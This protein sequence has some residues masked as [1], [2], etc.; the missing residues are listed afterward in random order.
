MQF[1]DSRKRWSFVLIGIVLF[2]CVLTSCARV[3][4]QSI[5]S[6]RVTYAEAINKTENEQILLSIVKGRYGETSS[7]LAVNG[8]AANMR[9]NAT[10]GIELGFGASDVSGENLLIGGLAYEENPTITYAPVQGEK[11][12]RQ[13]SSPIP[14]DIVMLSLRSGT[15]KRRLLTLLVSRINDLRNPSFLA[16]PSP[17]TDQG[18]VRF[19]ELFTELHDA[20]LLDMVENPQPEIS[21]DVFISD[22]SPR[23]RTQVHDF[24]KLLDLP[25]P[26]DESQ[27]LVIPVSFSIKKGNSWGL[28]IT[29]RSTFDLIEILRAAVVIPPEHAEEGL[30]VEYPPVGLP[31]QGVRIYSSREKPKDISLAVL[32]RGYWFYCSETDQETK[33]FFSVLRTLWSIIIAEAVDQRKT[34]VLTLPVV[35]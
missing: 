21:F 7:L 8:V 16:G 26:V 23:Y 13:L 34:P 17:Q 3:G 15:S 11:Y 24:L 22:Y 5:S 32:Y 28:G 29:T 9:F 10:A 30:S 1:I 27:D 19:V 18:F 35:R 25:I 31:G 20:G 4:P 2:L 12:I 33:A 14:L 6:G